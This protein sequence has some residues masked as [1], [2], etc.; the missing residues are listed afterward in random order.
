MCSEGKG[1]GKGANVVR[2]EPL[3]KE[4]A[5]EWGEA[6]SLQNALHRVFCVLRP[7]EAG[8]HVC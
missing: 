4:A 8:P 7:L 1:I 3:G 6:G 2:G 5:L